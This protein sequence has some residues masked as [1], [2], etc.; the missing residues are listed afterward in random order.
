[1][2]EAIII[3]NLA[4][5]PELKWINKDT[6]VTKF[7]IATNERWLDKDGNKMEK[8]DWHNCSAWGKRAETIHK[9]VKKGDKIMVKGKIRNNNFE[10]KEGGKVYGYEIV[11]ENFEFCNGKKGD[12]N[13]H[14]EPPP[15]HDGIAQE[16]H[17]NTSENNK[18]S[19]KGK[20]ANINGNQD[21]DIPF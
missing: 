18:N 21:D 10:T 14:S 1:M 5:D 12:S 3:G 4:R 19:G 16:Q 17:S 8:T 7:Q 2:N 6:C 13:N 15:Q 20:Q 11:V 9:Y